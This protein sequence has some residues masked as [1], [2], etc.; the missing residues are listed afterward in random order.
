PKDKYIVDGFNGL[1]SI[2]WGEVNKIVPLN[3][4][5]ELYRKSMHYMQNKEL[6]VQDAYAGQDDHFKLN[7]RIITESP[8]QSLFTYNMFGRIGLKETSSFTPDWH[9]I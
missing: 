8:W 9:I 2:W 7:L 5:N 6:Y 1:D 4:Y 3:T